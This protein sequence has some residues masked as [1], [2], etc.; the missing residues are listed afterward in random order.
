MNSMGSMNEI[1]A[2]DTAGMDSSEPCSRKPHRKSRNGC[3]RCKKRKVKVRF[4]FQFR[5]S[6]LLFPSFRTRSEC[7]QSLSSKVSSMCGTNVS[8]G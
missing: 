7:D 6:D 8:A 4:L 2:M 3:L 5:L 1:D